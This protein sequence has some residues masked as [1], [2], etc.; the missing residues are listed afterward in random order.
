MR[1]V[2]SIAKKVRK[3]R[4]HKD[5]TVVELSEISGVSQRTIAR[6]EDVG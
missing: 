1:A 5:L 3:L 4:A 2:K 6:L